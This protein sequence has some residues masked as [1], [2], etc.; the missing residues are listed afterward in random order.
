MKGIKI[1]ILVGFLMSMLTL[2]VALYF[3][4]RSY[5]S[6]EKSV[7]SLSTPNQS[8]LIFNSILSNL[9]ESENSMRD[10]SMTESET[11]FG[12]YL[13]SMELIDHDLDSIT[14]IF[15]SDTG[16][17]Q[18]EISELKNMLQTKADL[19]YALV[20]LRNL[21]EYKSIAS[22]T[23]Q[24]IA[25]TIT[26]SIATPAGQVENKIEPGL[27]GS[28]AT[29]DDKSLE[30]EKFKLKNLFTNKDKNRPVPPPEIVLF[31]DTVSNDANESSY[32]LDPN[33]S[34]D[35]E[36]VYKILSE[37][38][39]EEKNYNAQLTKQELEIMASGRVIMNKIQE[40]LTDMQTHYQLSLDLEKE[41]AKVAAEK[42]SRVIFGAAIIF[43]ILGLALLTVIINDINVN[44][45]Y[46]NQLESAKLKAEYL[47]R[48]KEQFLANMSHE[49]RTPLNAILGF[50]EQLQGEISGAKTEY[51]HSIQ[52]ASS[53]LLNLVNDIL[54]VSKIE[55]GKIKLQ[56]EIFSVGQLITEVFDMM[57]L[58][59]EAKHIVFDLH[60]NEHIAIPV[61]GDAFRLKQ[62]LLNLL[63]NAIKFTEQGKVELRCNALLK[64]R[65]IDFTF[66][67][68]DSGVGIPENKLQE[69]FNEFSQAEEGTSKKFGGT[70][71]GLSISKKLIELQKGTIQVKSKLGEGST[72]TVHIT[73]PIATKKEIEDETL[74]NL[75]ESVNVSG[76]KILIVDDEKLNLQL[77][78]IIC[79]KYQIISTCFELPE[80]AI[81]ELQTR[82]YDIVFIDLH[83]PV[84][85]GY[86]FMNT[87]YRIGI[88]NS[89]C[90]AL[91]ADAMTNKAVLTEQFGFD[92]LLLKPYTEKEFITIVQKWFS[93]GQS[94]L[95]V[96]NID[97]TESSD[98]KFF[99]LDEIKSFTNNDEVLT[100][101]IISTF[102][103][104]HKINI[105]ALYNFY[106]SGDVQGVNNMAH[107][108][109]PAF[110]HFGIQRAVDHLKYLEKAESVD[111]EIIEE[112]IVEL[113]D[114]A[115]HVF[116][117]LEKEVTVE[118][119][120]TA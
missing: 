59:A 79:D 62:I 103:Q 7:A 111:R 66:E 8:V 19:M 119:K 61:K 9:V 76:C 70:G 25:G 40:L 29:F 20:E 108:M 72:F 4:Y 96:L 37:I 58:Q 93:G 14:R 47:A 53:H 68:E 46:K 32:I 95:P 112:K 26:D 42:S 15:Q 109:I 43:F 36:I 90:I 84:I 118:N 1:K 117:Q 81:Q 78:K 77:A 50:S 106:I 69:I 56:S 82:N 107:K 114:V 115:M 10:Y 30:K 51:I 97:H 60:T 16:T 87:L 3:A 110:S 2:S 35:P 52:S 99:T 55:A 89:P 98:N 12:D 23:M 33:I 80:D 57:K 75:K 102:I 94:Q 54:D 101:E 64:E 120:E 116:D 73:Y 88:K 18:S 105:T 28:T 44:I 5:N 31:Q 74:H 45:R 38:N 71:L 113:L 92:D 63:S 22:R 39:R 24:D 27:K 41:K 11:A 104:E 67:V 85:D 91:T 48:S 83:M 34:I 86:S 21:P 100:S 6:L 13:Y 65:L 49:I 17:I